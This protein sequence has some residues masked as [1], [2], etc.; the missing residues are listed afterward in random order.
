V[1]LLC[2]QEEDYKSLRTSIDNYDH[3]DQIATAQKI[4]NHPLLEFRRI[5]AHLYKLNK[6]YKS[7]IDLSK[8]DEL[9]PDAMET[10]ATSGDEALAES[11]LRFFVDKSLRE[12]YAACLYICY[13]LIHPDT[14][15]ELSWRCNLMNF[16]MPFMVQCLRDYDDK[17]RL[18]NH[19]LEEQSRKAAEDEEKKKKHQDETHGGD[20]HLAVMGPAG[21]YNPLA[22][23]QLLMPPPG[24]YPAPTYQG[25]TPGFF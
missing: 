4:G 22:G 6:R 23:P 21:M 19:K 8:H 12:C 10:A 3:F 25:Q 2:L 1:N 11:L 16:A 7:S 14:V 24:M 5:A 20:A 18:I 17:V 9:W 15:L 13:D